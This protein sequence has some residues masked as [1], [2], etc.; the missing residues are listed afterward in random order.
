ML[1]S[2]GGR[3]L[4]GA[5]RESR[6][7][8]IL[9]ACIGDVLA[10]WTTALAVTLNRRLGDQTAPANVEDEQ[11]A[12]EDDQNDRQE[13]DRVAGVVSSVVVPPVIWGLSHWSTVPTSSTYVLKPKS[14]RLAMPVQPAPVRLDH[15]AP[16]A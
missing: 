4:D 6:R 5:A 9:L 12:E 3:N 7:P 14:E 16:P 11:A 8:I 10:V 2:S 13:P 15:P 1:S